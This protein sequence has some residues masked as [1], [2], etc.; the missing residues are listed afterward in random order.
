MDTDKHRFGMM[1]EQEL[2]DIVAR[3]E[4][5]TKA[6]WM[7]MLQTD[8]TL[9]VL[10]HTVRAVRISG[11]YYSHEVQSRAVE[12]EVIDEDGYFLPHE[13]ADVSKDRVR[14]AEFIASARE[15]IPKLIATIREL[16]RKLAEQAL[17]NT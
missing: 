17:G 9:R 16:Q 12:F 10:S 1:T 14:T 6:P 3:C 2:L 11:D 8:G 13:N 5:A 15:D 7:V 4:A